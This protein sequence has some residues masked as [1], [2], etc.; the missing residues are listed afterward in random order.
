MPI[1]RPERESEPYR[2]SNG[3]EG[4]IFDSNGDPTCTAFEPLITKEIVEYVCPCNVASEPCHPD[5]AC[6][7]PFSSKACYCCAKYGDEEQRKMSAE[8]IIKIMRFAHTK[9]GFAIQRGIF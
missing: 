4:E 9:Q 8:F 7:T 1:N 3:T 5:C 6:R 2:P